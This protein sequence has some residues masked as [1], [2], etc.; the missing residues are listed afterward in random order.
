MAAEFF[1]N[2]CS[3][4]DLLLWGK[5]PS[6]GC[7][8]EDVNRHLTFRIDQRD[9]DVATLPGKPRTY[10]IKQPRTVLRDYLQHTAAGRCF[11]VKFH[12]SLYPGFRNKVFASPHP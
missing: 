2:R 5:F 6:L 11:L 12:R 10:S 8:V 4:T 9:L 7:E 1:S 3:H